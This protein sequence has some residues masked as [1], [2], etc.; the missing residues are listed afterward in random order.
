MFNYNQQNNS[1]NE[2]DSIKAISNLN[3]HQ[4]IE[5]IH[6]GSSPLQEERIPI[7]N[8]Q[9]DQN[10]ESTMPDIQRKQDTFK[11]AVELNAK[12]NIENFKSIQEGDKIKASPIVIN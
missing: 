6:E 1:E 10:F 4:V 3:L 5:S 7:S 12:L 2:L 11:K 9:S 8:D